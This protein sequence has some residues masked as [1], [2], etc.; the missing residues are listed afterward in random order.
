[1]QRRARSVCVAKHFIKEMNTFSDSPLMIHKI[2]NFKKKDALNKGMS[3]QN[4]PFPLSHL[5]QR[6]N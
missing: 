6:I 1:M 3:L 2:H 5:E 4:I